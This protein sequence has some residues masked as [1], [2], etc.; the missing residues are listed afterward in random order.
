MVVPSEIWEVF[1]LPMYRYDRGLERPPSWGSYN[2]SAVSR[3]LQSLTDKAELNSY[4]FGGKRDG[5]CMY[6]YTYNV[7]HGIIIS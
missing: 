2:N 1:V 4:I 7:S 3:G 5:V 6:M